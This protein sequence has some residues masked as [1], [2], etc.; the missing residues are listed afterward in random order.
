M[1]DI[2][3]VQPFYF[4]FSDQTQKKLELVGEFGLLGFVV[5][6]VYE[7][8]A[9]CLNQSHNQRKA[10]PFFEIFVYLVSQ[11]HFLGVDFRLSDSGISL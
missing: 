9:F 2:F 4:S 3:L 10:Q 7:L 5:A 1:P 6:F 11:I 8:I